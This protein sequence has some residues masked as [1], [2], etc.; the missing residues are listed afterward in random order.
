MYTFCEKNFFC[1]YYLSIEGEKKMLMERYLEKDI[2][3]KVEIIN[4]LW[5]MS[6]VQSKKIA[7]EL[8]VSIV[9]VRNYIQD[10][11]IKFDFFIEL[12]TKY[13]YVICNKN[14]LNKQEYLKSIY[15]DS[16]FLKA[17]FYF[18]KNNFVRVDLFAKNEYIS[19]SKAY[20]LRNKVIEYIRLLGIET[21]ETLVPNNECK[22]RF[23]ITYFQVIMGMDFITVTDVDRYKFNQL[24]HA[25]ETS[26]KCVFSAYSKEYA[27][28]LFQLHFT[29]D[30]KYP[31]VF[32]GE[33]KTFLEES[34]MYNRLYPIIKEFLNKESYYEVRDDAILYFILIFVIMNV[35]Y[36]DNHAND[37]IWNLYSTIS[38]IP[39]VNRLVKE[40]EKNFKRSLSNNIV[41]VAALIPFTKKCVFNLQKFIPEEHYEIGHIAE[42]PEELVRKVRLIFEDWKEKEQLELDFSEDHI[43]YFTSKLFFIL[44]KKKR[45]KTIYLLTSFYTD[46]LFAKEILGDEYGNIANIKQ[47]NP[48]KNVSSYNDEDLILYDAQYD[49]LKQIDCKK[50]KITY[51][52]DIEELTEIRKELFG[53]S[54]EGIDKRKTN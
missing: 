40:F 42:I 12:D 30:L 8:G 9:T 48:Q 41:F 5:E 3:K 29:R 24:F 11:N 6:G 31:V 2:I 38:Q 14:Q 26:E 33:S 21:Q 22:T 54:L 51:I 39:L 44:N 28:L 15:K 49:I 16:L 7:K 46:Y 20:E 37:E 27:G 36:Y 18:L 10:L 32:S 13:G 34:D 23:L 4:K 17:C 47:F 45:I 35:N 52:F 50:K 1:F 19:F 53:Y 25:L 43:K